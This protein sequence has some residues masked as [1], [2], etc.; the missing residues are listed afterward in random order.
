VA[1]TVDRCDE[2]RGCVFEPDDA[3]CP[4]T[5]CGYAVCDPQGGCTADAA[6]CDCVALQLA[7]HE[8]VS[9]PDA[10]AL[11]GGSG[12]SRTFEL[13]VRLDEPEDRGWGAPLL[14]KVNGETSGD[15]A[16]TALGDDLWF[17]YF[18]SGSTTPLVYTVADAVPAGTWT[19]VAVVLDR[20]ARRTRVLVN[21]AAALDEPSTYDMAD[22]TAPLYVGATPKLWPGRFVGALDEVRV[23]TTARTGAA[24]AADFDRPL[25]GAETGLAAY[26]PFADAIDRTR[27]DTVGPTGGALTFAAGAEKPASSVSVLDG[28]ACELAQRSPL[29]IHTYMYIDAGSQGVVANIEVANPQATPVDLGSYELVLESLP[30]GRR[31]LPLRD[32]M[33]PPG[34]KWY[35]TLIGGAELSTLVPSGE[36]AF[37]AQQA[38]T[39]PLGIGDALLLT[40][41]AGLVVDSFGSRTNGT[42]WLTDPNGDGTRFAVR[43]CDVLAGDR[44]PDDAFLLGAEWGDESTTTYAANFCGS[45]GQTIC[46]PSDEYAGICGLGFECWNARQ[47]ILDR[48]WYSSYGLMI[49][50]PPSEYEPHGIRFAE[51]YYIDQFEA[52]TDAF[53]QFMNETNGND[54][55]YGGV[56]YPC[57]DVAHPN[58]TVMWDGSRWT[59][60]SVC[61]LIPSGTVN[62][63]CAVSPVASATWAGGRAFCAWIGARLC[64]DSEWTRAA[65]GPEG[66]TY[67]WGDGP[68]PGVEAGRGL[69]NCRESHCADGWSAVALPLSCAPG[70]SAV[71][72]FH[73]AGNVWEWVEDDW[74]FSPVDNPADGTPWVSEPRGASRCVRGGGFD[75]YASQVGASVRAME[76]I[77]PTSGR[78]VGVR[79]C[80]DA[81]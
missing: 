11:S 29:L 13:W 79:C 48:R 51:G 81:D 43:R 20:G 3:L 17:R 10:A 44:D 71:G 8:R 70:V 1:C 52:T 77:V 66:R 2:V 31:A 39:M 59:A 73:M 16:L 34:G 23:W 58:A 21:G 61:Q 76:P 49:F 54:C 45:C 18:R 33:L 27:V 78:P 42:Q 28:G 12:Q 53:I 22:S 65:A 74:H 32:V 46:P 19:H 9:A 63:S 36:L 75:S 14:T 69:A 30:L 64:S 72:A 25:A 57:L 62:N 56:T 80:R 67:P 38:A 37:S 68:S 5:G 6:R 7:G 40:T 15:W 50:V 4:G 47:Q 26:W 24:I 60:R 35:V 41:A 55:A